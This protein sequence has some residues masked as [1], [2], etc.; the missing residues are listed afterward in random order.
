MNDSLTSVAQNVV[1]FQELVQVLKGFSA[2]GIP[3]VLLKGAALAGPAYGDWTSRSMGD[4]DLWLKS[5]DM[6][7]AAV[8]MQRLGFRMKTK[9]DRP[10]A[11]QS[12][13][14]GEIKFYKLGL[15]E[16]HWSPFAGWW[17]H[18]TADVDDGEIWE[19]AEPM[20]LAFEGSSGTKSSTSE[21]RSQLVRQLAAEDM[22]IQV[23]VHLAVNH[24]F[25]MAAVRGLLDIALTAHTRPL[26]WCVVAE[27]AQRWRVRTAVWAVLDL[28]EQ[29]IGLPGVREA[30]IS[31]SPTLLR[32][33]LLKSVVSPRS[34]LEGRDLRQSPLRYLIL[35]LLVD[36]PRDATYLVFRTL[37]PEEEWL[38]ARY[39]EQR[40]HWRHFW[41]VLLHGQV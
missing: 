7:E 35:L 8:V 9:K 4:V 33:A 40:S 23:A 41:N 39:G 21:F 24:Q 29:L 15:V 31:L 11:L 26:D 16:L 14:G 3:V 17:L 25:G 27:R 18:R 38:R 34:V 36:R 22:V 30:L 20:A 32:R 28:A 1:R 12:L 13:A 6:Q 10:P 5:A 37:W 19:R 2:A